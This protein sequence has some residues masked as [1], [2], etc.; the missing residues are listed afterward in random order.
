MSV[1]GL[2]EICEAKTAEY[3]CDRCG[4]LACED[5]F[6]PTRGY[7]AECAQALGEPGGGERS[8]DGPSPGDTFQF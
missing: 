5:H 4:T 2:C 8:P 3:A 7:C 1:S 6:D